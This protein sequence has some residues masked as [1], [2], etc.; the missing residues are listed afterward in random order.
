[1]IFLKINNK[2]VFLFLFFLSTTA[3]SQSYEYSSISLKRTNLK[4][5][6]SSTFL[7]GD[8]VKINFNKQEKLYLITYLINGQKS[9]LSYKVVHES[10]SEVLV[11]NILTEEMEKYE[12]KD[13]LEENKGLKFIREITLDNEV[14][15]LEY[16]IGNVSN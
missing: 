2:F 3:V 10:K 15:L 16:I 9:H 1:M 7:L 11:I 8:S 6:H 14:F 5:K 13:F 4:S 12:V